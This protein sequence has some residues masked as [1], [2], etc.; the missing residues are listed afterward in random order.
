MAKQQGKAEEIHI[1]GTEARAPHREEQAPNNREQAAASDYKPNY[2][3]S[4]RKPATERENAFNSLAWLLDGATGLVEEAR[5]SDFGLSQ[6]FW[7]H[8]NAMRREGLL[9][10]R[11]VIDS[12]L[13]QMDQAPEEAE[14]RRKRQA[15]RGDVKV[16]F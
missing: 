10:A 9:A 15:R 11:A 2:S 1:T 13:A 5:H 12:M 3:E 7:V 14:E 8:Y 4:R 16:D 6:E